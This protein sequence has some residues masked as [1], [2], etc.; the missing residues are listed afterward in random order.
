MSGALAELYR[1]L[2]AHPEVAFKEHRTAAVIAARV[3]DLGYDV[4]EGVGVTGV[5]AMLRNGPGPTVLL[6]ADMDA[7]PMQEKTGLPY[8]SQI[9]G[10]MHACGHDM[11]VT[12]LIGA[13]EVLQHEKASW[14][15]TVMAVFQP[16]EEGGGGAQVMVDDGLFTRFAVPDVA[17]GQHVTPLPAGTVGFRPGAFMA[18]SDELRVRLFGR[19]GHGSRPEATVDPVV[20]AAST[21]MR[22]QTVVSREVAPIDTAVVTV[23]AIHAGTTSNIIAPEAELLLTIRTF[24]NAVRDRVHDAIGRIIRAEASASNAPAEPEITV[25]MSYPVLINDPIAT[26]RTIAAIGAEVGAEKLIEQPLIMGAEDFGTYGTVAGIPSVFW[27]VGSTDV[28]VYAKAEQAGR[29]DQ[30]IPSNHSPY[31]A[32]IL[33]PTLEFGIRTMVAAA[34]EW[35]D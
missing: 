23:G 13:L 30:D 21:I 29:L 15:G 28:D 27:Y 6:R 18:A 31:F 14:S 4:T 10:A 17:L 12:W 8:A 2:H 22:L 20:M 35:L 24:S 34:R 32:P 7:L 11:H 3:R 33:D 1:Q 26:S 9:D 16:A 19:G 25:T 5:V